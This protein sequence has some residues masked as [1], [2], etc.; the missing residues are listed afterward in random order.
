MVVV[1][2]QPKFD[3]A[4]RNGLRREPLIGVSEGSHSRLR[5]GLQCAV[6]WN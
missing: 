1:L 5:Q 6:V 4:D 3:S 2:P